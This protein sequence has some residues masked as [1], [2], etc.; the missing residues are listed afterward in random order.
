VTRGK[1]LD[2]QAPTGAALSDER[3]RAYLHEP[4]D[5]LAPEQWWR[6]SNGACIACE[7]VTDEGW[8]PLYDD[9]A[10]ERILAAR[11]AAGQP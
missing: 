2:G 3:P 4:C 10:V 11:D 5:T 1:Q 6:E 8:T 9:H 7:W